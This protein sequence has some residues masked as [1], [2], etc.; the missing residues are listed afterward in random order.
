VTRRLAIAVAVVGLCPA[1]A[2]A[3]AAAPPSGCVTTC[4]RM[5][6]RLDARV[7]RQA[8]KGHTRRAHWLRHR[9]ARIRLIAPYRWWLGTTGACESGTTTSLQ[10]G[11]T[12]V[13]KGGT[14][15]GRYQFDWSSWEAAGGHGDPA[16]ANWIEQAVRAVRWRQI[17][18]ISGWP[19]CG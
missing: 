10:A 2:S 17:R 14:Y 9:R 11:L 16:A 15:R 6:D 7:K 4:D 13:S 1:P 8:A 19:V 18:G 3:S 12:A 5:L